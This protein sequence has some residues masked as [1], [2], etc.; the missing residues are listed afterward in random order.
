M[1]T[2]NEGKIMF[3]LFVF[4]EIGG[5]AWITWGIELVLCGDILFLNM[6]WFLPSLITEVCMRIK[7]QGYY[8]I[9]FAVR[10][11]VFA[12]WNPRRLGKHFLVR[13]FLRS[14]FSQ[15][16]PIFLVV[17]GWRNLP[18]DIFFRGCTCI[19]HYLR[20]RQTCSLNTRFFF[21]GYYTTYISIKFKY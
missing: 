20:R 3:S 1:K 14:L 15:V 2:W 19:W 13:Y 7:V 21:G 17:L 12:E 8:L 6:T 4:R 5:W 10:S 9:L 11:A 16:S 18:R